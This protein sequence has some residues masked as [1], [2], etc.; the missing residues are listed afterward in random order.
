VSIPDRSRSEEETRIVERLLGRKARTEYT[1]VARCPDGTPQVLKV[2]P[3]FK[4]E[5]RWK[6]FPSYFWLVCPRLK[7]EISRLEETNHIRFFV[8]KL[9]KDAEFMREFIA[10]QKAITAARLQFALEV[11]RENLPENL[12]KILSTVNISGSMWQYG[13]KCLHAHTAQTIAF[14]RNPI[15]SAVMQILGPC[16]RENPCAKFI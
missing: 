7:L 2:H 6:P 16:S 9:Q 11:T 1:V 4:E 13:V 10:G 5:G 8:E 14:G 12:L 15:G 3:V